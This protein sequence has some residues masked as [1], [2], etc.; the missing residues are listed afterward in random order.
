MPL[1]NLRCKVTNNNGASAAYTW[2]AV[3]C[4]DEAEAL[5]A[6]ARWGREADAE[7]KKPDVPWEY[8][9]R[10]VE[11]SLPSDE[12]L[13]REDDEHIRDKVELELMCNP[14]WHV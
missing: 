5:A 7:Y 11:P 1:F 13:R 8:Q 2:R 3:E 4:A 9:T 14:D 6:A 12:T 10:S